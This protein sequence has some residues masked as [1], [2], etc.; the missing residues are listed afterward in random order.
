MSGVSV[1]LLLVLLRVLLLACSL[2]GVRRCRLAG[3]LGIE[4]RWLKCAVV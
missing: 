3:C 1:M 2:C 4:D